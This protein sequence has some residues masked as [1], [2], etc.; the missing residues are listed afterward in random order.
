MGIPI[1]LAATEA[2]LD[3]LPIPSRNDGKMK[4]GYRCG[5]RLMITGWGFIGISE[6]LSFF[7]SFKPRGGVVSCGHMGSSF[8]TGLQRIAIYKT[9]F[10]PLRSSVHATCLVR[11]PRTDSNDDE[12]IASSLIY[13]NSAATAPTNARSRRVLVETSSRSL[14]NS[15]TRIP[16]PGQLVRWTVRNA[17]FSD[18]YYSM[19]TNAETLGELAAVVETII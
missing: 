9:S 4:D 14:R 18:W 8:G 15:Q 19:K 10:L 13:H 5:K 12:D 6:R 11:R 17:T 2:A 3:G 1:A 16:P 7:E